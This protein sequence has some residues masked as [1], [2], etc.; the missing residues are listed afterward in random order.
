MKD[1]IKKHLQLII[2]I[3]FF[4]FFIY[5][6]NT[7]NLTILII[8]VAILVFYTFLDAYLI[9]KA[10]EYKTTYLIVILETLNA[11]SLI[12]IV[13]FTLNRPLEINLE[14]TI[15]R[16]NINILY[17]ITYCIITLIIQ[18]LKSD[19]FKNDVL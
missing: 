17:N 1:F 12:F 2:L 5:A 9:L 3:L 4:T 13:H 6:I 19:G 16:L 10:K 14:N 7:D 11:L 15:T 18:V 8:S